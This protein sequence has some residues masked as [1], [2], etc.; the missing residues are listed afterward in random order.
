MLTPSALVTAS[1]PHDVLSILRQP[2][3]HR[4]SQRRTLALFRQLTQLRQSPQRQ[5]QQRATVVQNYLAQ[6][7]SDF[8]WE[9]NANGEPKILPDTGAKDGLCGERWAVH[10]GK[11][12]LARGHRCKFEPLSQP[13]H[14]SGVGNGSQ[15]VEEKVT[16]P[17]GLEDKTGSKHLTNFRAAV[18]RGS[19]LP[20]LLGINSLE[21]MNAVIKCGTGE[22]WFMDER[23]C[24]IKPR[25]K[26]LHLQMQKGSSG[27]W[28]LPVG[29][30]S[31]AMEKLSLGHLA[32][33]TAAAATA[34]S[35][36]TAAA[37]ASCSAE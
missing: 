27:H 19:D 14:V 13:K 24:D 1:V 20:A 28:F 32:T 18:V 29:R 21:K 7:L 5:Q 6:Y 35:T 30:F 34:A 37:A 8:P 22:I 3:D 10:A 36:P 2:S 31:E 11:W 17:I 26:H 12:A 25:G 33:T 4:D 15:R 16:V 23:G 9:D